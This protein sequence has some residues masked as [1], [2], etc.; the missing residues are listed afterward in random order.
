MRISDW[1]SDVCSSD[2]RN[3]LADRLREIG[4]DE[5]T[6][7]RVVRQQIMHDQDLMT[8]RCMAESEVAFEELK[9]LVRAFTG[10][11]DFQFEPHFTPRYR[12]SPQRLPF[13]SEESRVGKEGS[14]TWGH[15][16]ARYH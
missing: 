13:R 9:E 2:L 16:G 3:E 10:K 1:S 8:R 11:P 12:V 15:G 6:V 5:P 4:I 7:H 14:S